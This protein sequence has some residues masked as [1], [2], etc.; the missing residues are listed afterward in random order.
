[1]LLRSHAPCP[2][3]PQHSQ[4]CRSRHR[5][6]GPDVDTLSLSR[7]PFDSFLRPLQQGYMLLVEPS[8]LSYP[9]PTKVVVPRGPLQIKGAATSSPPVVVHPL[10][11]DQLVL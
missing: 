4:T 8:Y 7:P 6:A 11:P 2:P 5:Q 9:S 10:S 1:M 3:R